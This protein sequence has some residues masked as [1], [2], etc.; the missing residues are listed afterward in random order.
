[1]TCDEFLKRSADLV[2][3]APPPAGAEPLQRHMAVCS[4][5]AEAARQLQAVRADL[6]WAV[7]SSLDPA[8]LAA[9]RMSV[10]QR[11]SAPAAPGFWATWKL[12]I[13]LVLAGAAS[14]AVAWSVRHPA[15]RAPAPQIAAV[16]PEKQAAVPQSALHPPAAVEPIRPADPRERLELPPA[17]IEVFAQNAPPEAADGA[18]GGVILK[19]PSSNPDVI[20]YWLSDEQGGS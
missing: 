6:R 17:E 1:M 7:D 4:R 12:R 14:L 20:L 11:L 16:M 15:D 3:D 18:G 9:V 10:L 5:C 13:A 2:E 8:A 19:L